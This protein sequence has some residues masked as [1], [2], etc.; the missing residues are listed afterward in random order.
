MDLLETPFFTLGASSRDNRRRIMELA[1]ERSLL[2]DSNQCMKARSELTN[3]RKRL[4]AEIAWLPGLRPKRIEEVL[5]LLNSSPADTLAVDKL[6]PIA[7]ANL[8]ASGLG[9]LPNYN[10]D[11]VSQ[12]VLEISWT[13]EDVAPE[14]LSVLINEERV[15]SGFP[16]VSDISAIETEIQE[17]RRHYRNVIKSALDKLSS[18]ELVQAVTIVVEVATHD[19][20]EQGPILIDDL[21]DSYEIEAQGFLE[22]EEGNIRTLVDKLR[23]AADN[24]KADSV[25]DPMVS[26]LIQVVK[27]WDVVAQPIQVSTKSRGLNHEA[28]HRI[29]GLV[30]DLAIHLFNQ[31]NKLN[32]SQQLTDMLL[33]VFA[34]V[35]EV[36]EQTAKDSEALAD[37]KKERDSNNLLDPISSLCKEAI[38]ATQNSPSSADK[39]AQKV[40]NSSPQ[41]LSNLISSKPNTEILSQGKD[42]IALTLMH[43]AVAY[44]NK[45]EKWGPCASFLEKALEYAS[46]QETKS[47]IQKNLAIVQKNNRLNDDLTSISS[48]PSLYTINGIG[49]TMYG[50][51][52]HDP[53][54]NSHISTYYFVFLAIPIFPISRYRVISNGNQYRFLAKAPLRAFD[55]WHLAASLALIAWVIL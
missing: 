22:E 18:K 4:S 8:I 25:L 31:H 20:D 48:A 15:A 28:S 14:E 1:D 35:G 12:W 17:R 32:S 16:E 41:L 5:S 3:P 54:S 29:A 53:V 33:E 21:V 50:A 38:K 9:Q 46:T 19:G 55:K 13:F 7:R 2:L 27:N 26:Q 42:Q 37:I 49:M 23:S 45:T 47:N 52:D 10:T 36:A 39:E 34:E 43:C 30:R 11:E 24:E 44:G 40:I 51:T 6:S